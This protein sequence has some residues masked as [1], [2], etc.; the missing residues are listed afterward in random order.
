MSRL[1]ER[2]Q[3]I[4]DFEKQQQS[5]ERNQ[6]AIMEIR[7]RLLENLQARIRNARTRQ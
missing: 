2:E 7:K 5:K 3:T 1:Q 4:R 6:Q